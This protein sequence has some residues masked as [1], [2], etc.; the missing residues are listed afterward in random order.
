[1]GLFRKNERVLAA[2]SGGIDSMVLADLLL[3]SGSLAGI[4]HCNFT[5][6]GSESDGDEE[7]VKKF[8][9][10]NKIPFHSVRFDTKKYAG[11]R[12]ISIEMAARELRYD[13]FE[14]IRTEK[15]YDLIAVA[16]NM[17][18]NAETLLLNL[19]RGTGIAGLAGMKPKAGRIIRPLLFSTRQSIEGYAKTRRI[20]FRTD[21]TNA[22]TRYKRNKIRHELIPIMQELNPSV[23][24]TL[25]ETALR[26]GGINEIVAPVITEIK[27]SFLEEKERQIHVNIRNMQPYWNNSVIMFEVFRQFGITG[28]LLKD[29]QNVA[30]GRTGGRLFT[31]TH[32]FLRDRD[33]IIISEKETDEVVQYN[34]K[35][36]GEIT[37]CP[38]ISFSRIINSG[39]GLKID[40]SKEMAYLDLKKVAFPITIRK[41]QTGDYF[42]PFGMSGR[43]KISD[44]FI[45]RKMTRFQKD[46]AMVLETDGKIA[47]IIGER[48]DN[49]FRVTEATEKVLIMKACI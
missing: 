13:W 46:K 44:Y 47:W 1:M 17:N 12:G 2:V 16:H 10:K 38:H 41:W 27:K 35:S 34:F 48:I 8:S 37:K 32:K 36:S 43:K 49:R 45:D 29:L 15:G 4:A 22:E 3:E 24:T 33:K 7:M 14:K 40:K 9:I 6:R 39:K 5:L 42:Y 28:A 20:K 21:S 31:E 23:L 26:L 19:I 11:Q 30:T 25:H 18:D